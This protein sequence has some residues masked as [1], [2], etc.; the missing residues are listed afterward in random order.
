MESSGCGRAPD[1]QRLAPSS[2]CFANET[3]ELQDF[4]DHQTRRRAPR[5]LLVIFSFTHALTS[6]SSS[7]HRPFTPSC[8]LRPAANSLR[9]T[10]LFYHNKPLSAPL[11]LCTCHAPHL[12]CLGHQLPI[13][14]L[15]SPPPSILH[16]TRVLKFYSLNKSE[17]PSQ[18]LCSKVLSIPAL[19]SPHLFVPDSLDHTI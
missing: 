3:D 8:N 10:S 18:R 12:G 7:S 11:C 9:P 2:C 6:L 5:T 4:S 16:P 13:H 14:P 15:L 17:A 1:G 19:I